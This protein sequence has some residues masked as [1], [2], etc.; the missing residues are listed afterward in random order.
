MPSTLS[1][2]ISSTSCKPMAKTSSTAFETTRLTFFVGDEAM[3]DL[4]IDIVAQT[5]AEALAEDPK[6]G[7]VS[8]WGEL[9]IQYAL[10]DTSS[11]KFYPSP[12]ITRLDDFWGYG[13][14]EWDMESHTGNNALAQ[15][16]SVNQLKINLHLW[17]TR[18]SR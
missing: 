3:P 7:K 1:S 12:P 14:L 17:S 13:P 2:P 5:P 9:F 10:A 15:G 4:L 6:L 16:Y 18:P 8:S 11:W